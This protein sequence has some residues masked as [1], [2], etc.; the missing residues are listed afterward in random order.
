MARKTP[1]PPGPDTAEELLNDLLD[2][3]RGREMGIL[4]LDDPKRRELN[5]VGALLRR[6]TG[7][8]GA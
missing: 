6:V 5:E 7:R 1:V 8:G 3:V 4:R 2:E